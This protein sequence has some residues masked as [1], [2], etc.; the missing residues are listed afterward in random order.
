MSA[1]L[2]SRRE[3]E[4]DAAIKMSERWIELQGMKEMYRKEGM[5]SGERGREG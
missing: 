1:I 5:N 4:R 2:C 3:G